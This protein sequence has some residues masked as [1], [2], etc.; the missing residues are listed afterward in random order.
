MGVLATAAQD[1]RLDGRQGYAGSR[2]EH[3]H[4]DVTIVHLEAA[5]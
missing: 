4:G 2:R 3:L 1:L 5:A